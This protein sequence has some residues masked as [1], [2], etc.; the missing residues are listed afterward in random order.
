M[1]GR[2]GL[3]RIELAA[4]TLGAFF[5]FVNG[6]LIPHLKAL[7]DQP[8]ASPRQKIVSEIFSGVERTRIDF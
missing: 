4:G 6:D 1:G 5:G 7:K 3:K 2:F 8:N